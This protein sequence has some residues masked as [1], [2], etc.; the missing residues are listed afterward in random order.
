MALWEIQDTLAAAVT[1]ARSPGCPIDG[2]ND[3]VGVGRYA[4]ALLHKRWDEMAGLVPL[5]RAVDGRIGARFQSWLRTHPTP[6]CDTILDPGLAE[7]LR[8]LGPLRTAV[9]ADHSLPAWTADL[10][11]FEIMSAAARADGRPRHGRSAYAI[12]RI[13][14]DVRAGLPPVSVDPAAHEY[15]FTRTGVTFRV[16]P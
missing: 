2:F 3:N 6:A 4:A 5:T 14:D 11:G 13:A 12:H 15:R 16:R 10:L 8:A 9:A 7:A 1:D